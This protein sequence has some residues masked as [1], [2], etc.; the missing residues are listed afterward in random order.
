M[1]GTW[2]RWHVGAWVHWHVGTW[3]DGGVGFSVCDNLIQQV[4]RCVH[5]WAGQCMDM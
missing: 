4:G 1:S 5:T 2:V 3:A